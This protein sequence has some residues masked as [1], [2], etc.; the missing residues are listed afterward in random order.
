MRPTE[1]LAAIKRGG[2]LDGKSVN[3]FSSLERR[4]RSELVDLYLQEHLYRPG[5]HYVYVTPD[6]ARYG[7][8]YW[9]P[10]VTKAAICANTIAPCSVFS[11]TLAWRDGP[12]SE[13]SYN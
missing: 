9:R 6:P 4:P 8:R 5:S 10:V 11:N 12:P 1:M 2:A 3:L 7:Y 13:R